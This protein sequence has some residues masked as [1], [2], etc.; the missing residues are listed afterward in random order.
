MLQTKSPINIVFQI[1][2]SLVLYRQLNTNTFN[3]LLRN[4]FCL[5]DW[6]KTLH[7]FS[8]NFINFLFVAWAFETLFA[9]VFKFVLEELMVYLSINIVLIMDAFFNFVDVFLYS[10]IIHTFW[11]QRH[12][13]IN[14]LARFTFVFS[15][16]NFK[17]VW[18][19]VAKSWID[20]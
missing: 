13:I 3:K 1:V 14:F 20:T 15:L 11:P 10:L 4:Y 18:T 9:V 2:P 5:L 7:W 16:L 12:N 17:N 19:D 8:F 6:S